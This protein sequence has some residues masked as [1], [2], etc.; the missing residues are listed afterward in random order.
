M[1]PIQLADDAKTSVSCTHYTDADALNQRCNREG[2]SGSVNLFKVPSSAFFVHSPA[3]AANIDGEQ[4][5]LLSDR[6]MF[7]SKQAFC[8]GRSGASLGHLGGFDHSTLFKRR[9]HW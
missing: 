1:P 8:L 5:S 3:V 2:D 9:L 4:P 6:V 7:L